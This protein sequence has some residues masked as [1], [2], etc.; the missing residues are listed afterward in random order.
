MN[1]PVSKAGSGEEALLL[2]CCP[3]SKHYTGIF[4]LCL[5]LCH[6]H[7]YKTQAGRYINS[8]SRIIIVYTVLTTLVRNLFVIKKGVQVLITLDP[9]IK[10]Q[11]DKSYTKLF[12][13]VRYGRNYVRINSLMTKSKLPQQWQ[14]Q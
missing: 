8:E 14:C 1:I 7:K 3:N 12:H 13:I 5:S 2:M 4:S 10:K 9:K 6:M 11:H